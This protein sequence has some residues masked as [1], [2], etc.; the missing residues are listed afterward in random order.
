MK[1]RSN[2]M[3][4]NKLNNKYCKFNSIFMNNNKKMKKI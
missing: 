1:I 3:I 2:N 4:Y